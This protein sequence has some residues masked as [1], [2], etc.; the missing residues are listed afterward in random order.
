[1]AANIYECFIDSVVREHH[2]YKTIWNPFVGEELV[3]EQENMR[4]EYP[5]ILHL[6]LRLLV[7]F[8]LSG[9]Y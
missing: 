9:A 8:C 7:S 2:V 6:Y 3:C 1:M 4:Q 5:C